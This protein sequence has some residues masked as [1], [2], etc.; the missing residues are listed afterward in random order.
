MKGFFSFIII[1][2]M[3]IFL[4]NS[5]IFFNDQIH[6]QNELVNKLIEIEYY[7]KERSILEIN[8]DTLIQKKLIEQ[9][10]SDDFD[11]IFS[12]QKINTALFNFLK[13]KANQTDLFLENPT[14]LSIDFLNQTTSIELFEVKNIKYA[15]FIFTSNNLKNKN[16]SKKFGK[17]FEILFKIPINYSQKM[18]IIDA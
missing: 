3:V 4:I 18:V 1:I 2:A 9:L 16:I 7:S 17:N 15:R 6:F 11:L 13:D 8:V 14:S 10:K 5:N 12:K